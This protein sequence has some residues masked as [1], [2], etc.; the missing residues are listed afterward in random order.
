M[1]VKMNDLPKEQPPRS[2]DPDFWD[3]WTGEVDRP[4]RWGEVAKEWQGK[5][6]AAPE[7]NEREQLGQ[8]ELSD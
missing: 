2:D 5:H 7:P 3:V 4:A 6:Q 1:L 8:D